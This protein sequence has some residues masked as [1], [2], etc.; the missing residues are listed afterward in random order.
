MAFIDPSVGSMGR[1]VRRY[2]G[3]NKRT[4]VLWILSEHTF[5]FPA[6]GEVKVLTT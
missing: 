4:K 5:S 2:S 3:V 6:P 1:E